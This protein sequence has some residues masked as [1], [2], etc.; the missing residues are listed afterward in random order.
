V[1]DPFLMPVDMFELDFPSL[2]IH[3]RA[4][5]PR[6]DMAL[7]LST[8]ARLK[9]NEERCVRARTKY[10]VELRDGEITMGYLR[11]HA[12]FIHREIQ[13]QGIRAQ[14]PVIMAGV[15]V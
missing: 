12:P 4:S 10:V 8:R 6:P 11:R 9:L 14:L 13:R 7:A 5:L 2:L 1:V 3:P 15:I